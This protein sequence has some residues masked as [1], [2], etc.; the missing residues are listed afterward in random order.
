MSLEERIVSLLGDLVQG[1]I[2]PDTTPDNA[3][4]PLITY[5]Q[6]GGRDYAYMDGS[7]PDHE[8]ARLQ[9]NVHG[10][11]RSE[12]KAAA[13]QVKKRMAADLQAEIYGSMTIRF[14]DIA[15]L[16]TTRQDFGCWFPQ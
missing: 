14:D 6:V 13:Q 3:V 8:H 16:F 4:F 11:I 9:I 7:L 10:R 5:H 12:A 2:Y 15:K 1:R